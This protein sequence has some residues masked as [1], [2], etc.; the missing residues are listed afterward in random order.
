[1]PSE[2]GDGSVLAGDLVWFRVGPPRMPSGHPFPSFFVSMGKEARHRR[3]ALIL[4]PLGVGERPYEKQTKTTP[5]T[6]GWAGVP[7]SA[8]GPAKIII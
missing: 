5:G 2:I 3:G 6:I 7:P 4:R 1:M 8:A